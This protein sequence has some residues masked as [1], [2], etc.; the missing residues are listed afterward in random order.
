MDELRTSHG[1]NRRL[2]ERV[3]PVDELRR[4]GGQMGRPGR[5]ELVR[6]G[7]P[8][9]LGPGGADACRGR[10]VATERRAH[11]ARVGH[12]R[13]TEG[14]TLRVSHGQGPVVISRGR[15]PAQ[16]RLVCFPPRRNRIGDR[17]E[18]VG[19]AKA[20]ERCILRGGGQFVASD[21]AFSQGLAP[22]TLVHGFRNGIL[23]FSD[24]DL[25]PLPEHLR[26]AWLPGRFGAIAGARLGFRQVPEAP[27]HHDLADAG[28]PAVP[29]LNLRR[30][31]PRR[32][33]RARA[34]KTLRELQAS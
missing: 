7:Q 34:T 25:L 6:R 33:A 8:E 1:T 3:A 21:P 2:P 12:I 10:H 5:C 17:S 22:H 28:S 31:L 24:P 15:R 30:G 26:D 19:L 23:V 16:L 20:A 27:M 18:L 11:A 32:G 29:L 4:G 13:A 9:A 14:E